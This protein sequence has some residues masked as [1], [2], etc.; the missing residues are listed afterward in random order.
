MSFQSE[1]QRIWEE[2][3][4]EMAVEK[5]AI[6]ASVLE[7]MR[8]RYPQFEREL[9]EMAVELALESKL[10]RQAE[11]P[12]G[13]GDLTLRTM[14]KV[15]ARLHG[16]L[17]KRAAAPSASDQNLFSDLTKG[18]S[19]SLAARLGAN[20]VFV[21]KLRD[22]MIEVATMSAGFLKLVAG[23]LQVTVEQLVTYLAAPPGMSLKT[24][25]KSDQK[26]AAAAKQSFAEAIEH[27]GLSKE[28]Q[29]YLL[30]L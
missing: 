29:E 16:I 20:T 3:C 30:G 24:S 23:E 27:I 15:Q 21:S 14:S 4:Y 8:S 7:A 5:D 12:I 9:T 6:D 25:Y 28:Q 26:P 18:K 17:V 10:G 11:A 19:R 13:D 1:N 22:R 2:I